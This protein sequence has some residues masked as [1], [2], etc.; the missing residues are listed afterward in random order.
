MEIYGD[1]DFSPRRIDSSY[2][3]HAGTAG[4]ILEME[5]QIL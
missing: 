3:R 5:P 4:G 1:L 2:P